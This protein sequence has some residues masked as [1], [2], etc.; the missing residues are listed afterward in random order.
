[1]LFSL[2]RVLHFP[3]DV[4]NNLRLWLASQKKTKNYWLVQRVESCD[5]TTKL[6]NRIIR[7]YKAAELQAS[8]QLDWFDCCQVKPQFAFIQL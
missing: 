8:K 3:E 2:Q 4:I 1:M 7:F 5:V 6:V